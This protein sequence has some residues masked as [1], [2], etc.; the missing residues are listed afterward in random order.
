MKA[1]AIPLITLFII[2]LCF[3]NVNF[4]FALDQDDF[5]VSP[6]WSTPLYYQGDSV[7]LKLILSSKSSEV[8]TVYY[9][10]VHFDWMEEDSFYGRDFSSDPVTVESSK[11]H[12]FDPMAITFPSDVSIG[13]HNYTIGIQ[14]SDPTSPDIVSWDS[15]ARTIYVHAGEAKAYR[16]LL[17]NVTAKIDEAINASYQNP[18]AQSLLDQATNEY[19]QASIS[20][21]NEQYE[22]AIAHLQAAENYVDQAAA[23]EQLGTQQNSEMMRLLWIVAPIVTAVIVSFIAIIVWRR[24]QPPSDEYDQPTETQEYTEEE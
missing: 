1:A 19:E 9:I 17:L 22:D 5:S 10:G 4:G 24:R 12:V 6:S 7:S 16:E 11:V 3:F 23:A 21:F 2:G 15:Q 8:L 14:I 20:S 13:L 18:E